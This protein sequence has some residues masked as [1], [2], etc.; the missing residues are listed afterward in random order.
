M[1]GVSNTRSSAG[2]AAPEGRIAPGC[3]GG[4]GGATGFGLGTIYSAKAP[5]L[6]VAQRIG[7]LPG[8][9]PITTS[10]AVELAGRIVPPEVDANTPGGKWGAKT[11]YG[12]G[13][14]TVQE[15]SSRYQ[16]NIPQGKVSGPFAKKWGI[17]QPGE[18]RDVVQRMIDRKN[19]AEAV[20]QAEILAAEKAATPSAKIL[21]GLGQIGRIGRA[22]LGSTPVKGGLAGFNIGQGI[23]DVSQRI[24][25]NEIG[26]AIASGL[27]TA[28]STAS[29]FVS[30]ALNVFGLPFTAGIPLYLAASDR[31]EYLE[32]HPDEIRLENP[33]RDALG[34]VIMGD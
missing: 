17:A 5:A 30:G 2:A 31:L 4:L 33:T 8:G 34:N 25:R 11:G 18:S 1:G 23:Q 7:L 3:A 15:T 12:I 9:K 13:E 6:R 27:S 16:R 28:A 14:G 10:D 26:E 32:Q 20:R 19:A 22:I 21:S 29:P 24:K